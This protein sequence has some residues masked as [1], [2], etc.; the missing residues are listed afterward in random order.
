M[1]GEMLG[2]T[3]GKITGNRV[4]PSEG[5]TPK[6]ESSY[7]GSGRILGVEVTDMGTFWSIFRKE[8]VLYGEGQ[9]VVMTRDGEMATW[10]GQGLGRIKGRSTAVSWRGSVLFQTSSQ[11][12]ARLGS[13]AVNFEFEVDED[14]NTYVKIWEWL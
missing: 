14:G 10:K 11:R 8:G 6:I 12:L 1:L 7:Q 5:P 4:L 3:Q 9:G 2:E 13:V